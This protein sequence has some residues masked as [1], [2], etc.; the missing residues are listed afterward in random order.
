MAISAQQVKELR[1]LTDCGIM[2]CKKALIEC[3]GDIEKAKGWLREKGMAK[4]EKKSSRVAAEGAVIAKIADDQKSGV[5]VE[6]NVET[7]FA[8]NTDNFKSFCDTV[9]NHIIEKKPASVEELMAQPLAS[10]P[11]KTVELFQKEAIAN[12][13]ENT[14]IRRFEIFE[15]TGLGAVTAYIHM[16]GKVGVFSEIAAGD[17]SV[18]SK[19][20]FADFAKNI[21]MQIAAS[22]PGWVNEADVPQDELAKETEILK[23]KAL[24]EGKPEKIVMERIQIKNFYKMNCLVDQEYIKDEDL[25]VGQ[26]IA[27]TA[28]ELGTELAVVRFTRFTLGE[29]IEKK[30]DDFAEEVRKQ[31]GL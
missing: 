14:S 13:G 31:A 1:D 29:G 23:N 25:T 8:A 28:K 3:D 17:D 20:E 5:L 16:G 4:A 21:N 15:N 24:E 30:Q 11:S 22:R 18:I 9:V 12:I 26:Y 10:D 7:D 27:K 2:D 6:I 19:P